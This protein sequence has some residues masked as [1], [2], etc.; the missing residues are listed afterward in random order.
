M[1]AGVYTANLWLTNLN[2][3]RAQLRQVSLQVGQN[4]V[5]DGGFECFDFAYWT[6]GGP[7]ASTNNFVDD[8]TY[9]GFTAHSGLYFAAL[10]QPY[11]YCSLSQILPTIAGQPY[12]ISYWIENPSDATPNQFIVEWATDTA[13]N[14]VVNQS[15]V[16]VATWQNIQ[17]ISV[18]PTNGAAIQFASQ[19]PT[20]YIAID[21]VSVVPVPLPTIQNLVSS[22]GSLQITWLTLSGVKYQVQFTPT[23][24]PS[25]WTNVGS[26]ITAS[27]ASTTVTE[28]IGGS[29]QGYYR[30]VLAAQ[31]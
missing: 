5:H 16:S 1:P 25:S 24:S 2:D 11:D 28:S 3:N 8:G 22:S 30:I 17:A 26:A 9:S 29:G 10:G 20:F 27:A 18:A 31:D 7:N 23:L 21:D 14:I 13:T 6:L 4:L 12:L 19:S 15:D